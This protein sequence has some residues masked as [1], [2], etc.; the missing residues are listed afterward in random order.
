M[1]GDLTF[2]PP[3]PGSSTR[4]QWAAQFVATGIHRKVLVIGSDVMTSIL[5]FQDR[6]T[7]VLFG[8]AAGAILLEPTEPG[9]EGILDFSHNIDGSGGRNL[10]MPAGGSLHPASHETVEQ[11]MHF[12]KQEGQQD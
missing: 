5:D 11:R 4:S 8:D 9:E 10:Y 6:A 3:A 2:P 12:V 7:C 1:P